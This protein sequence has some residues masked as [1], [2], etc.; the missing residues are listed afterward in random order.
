M[1]L[2]AI[3]ISKNLPWNIL[4]DLGWNSDRVSVTAHNRVSYIMIFLF[5]IN[6]G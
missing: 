5:I 1:T 6:I 4:S 3:Y 2:I